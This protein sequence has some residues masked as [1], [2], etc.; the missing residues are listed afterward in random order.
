MGDRIVVMKDG[1]I[2]Q[3]DTPQKLYEEPINKFVAGFLGSPQMNFIDAVLKKNESGQYYVEFGSEDTKNARGTK[4]QIVLPESKATGEKVLA[5]LERYVEREVILGVRPECVHDEDVYLASATTGV[6]DCNVEITEMMGA[7]TFLYL[8]CEGIPI[9]ARV[10]PRTTAHPGD[11]IKVC[12]DP[13]KIH[14]FDKETEKT[15]V[16]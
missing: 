12:L 6:I 3:T 8:E 10:S 16:N 11:Q 4:Y 2:Q 9:T 7:E 14:L 5:D 1:F 15:I 13:N